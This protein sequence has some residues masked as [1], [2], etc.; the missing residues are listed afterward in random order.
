MVPMIMQLFP[1]IYGLAVLTKHWRIFVQRSF[2][3]NR[4]V[5]VQRIRLSQNKPP[6]D[7]DENHA[8]EMGLI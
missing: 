2:I 6:S 3:D 5:I 8:L 7:G 1:I 4:Q